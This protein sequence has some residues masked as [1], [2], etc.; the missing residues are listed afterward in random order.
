MR[1]RRKKKSHPAEGP[2]RGSSMATITLSGARVKCKRG[3]EAL[4]IGRSSG[5][6][7]EI[8]DSGIVRGE[9][10]VFQSSIFTSQF[11]TPLIPFV[12]KEQGTESSLFAAR[13]RMLQSGTC[14]PRLSLL[15]GGPG[16]D[17]CA[18]MLEFRRDDGR[19]EAGLLAIRRI[20]RLGLTCLMN[21]SPSV[22]AERRSCQL[23][24][25]KTCSTTA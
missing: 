14:P 10:S 9:N 5:S 8:G 20:R 22:H 18:G 23:R 6:A 11:P 15:T 19:A 7:G 21:G 25:P 1:H 17:C 13:G 16:R 12:G 2:L 3:R 24:N 4:G